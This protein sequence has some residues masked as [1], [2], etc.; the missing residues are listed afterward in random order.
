MRNCIFSFPGILLCLLSLLLTATT[1]E[2]WEME[3]FVPLSA[4]VCGVRQVSWD[5]SGKVP[6]EITRKRC[7]KEA[8]MLSVIPEVTLVDSEETTAY[9]YDLLHPITA[10][11][12]ITLTDFNEDY[13]AGS[14]VY[15]LFYR[16]RHSDSY[17]FPVTYW[18]ESK[19]FLL[20]LLTYPQPGFYQ[21]RIELEVGTHV[22]TTETELLEFY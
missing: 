13:P 11:R 2:D 6:L 17:Y 12:I 8:Y 22:Y 14:N 19:Q 16:F 4:D 10:I 5:N 3:E 20:V 9:S 18:E 21:F 15:P 7:R 1:C